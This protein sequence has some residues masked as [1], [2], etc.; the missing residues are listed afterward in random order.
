MADPLVL[1]SRVSPEGRVVI[2]VEIRRRLGVAPG[3]QVQFVM[4]EDGLVELVTARMLAELVWAN[5]HGGD[6]LD[7]TEVVRG[8]RQRDQ[9][10]EAQA[11]ARVAADA[12]RPWDLA[13]ET[14]RLL[15]ALGL[16]A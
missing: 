7:S 2:P 3:D 6:A 1:A 9:M 15:A 5:N 14:A 10:V 11:E 4:R 16:D 13:Q 12:D 8:E